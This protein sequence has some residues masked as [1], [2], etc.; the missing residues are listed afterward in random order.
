ME[1]E[2]VHLLRARPEAAPAASV[3]PVP[4]D[5]SRVREQAKKEK[6]L[7]VLA[8]SL[9][10]TIVPVEKLQKDIATSISTRMRTRQGQHL[11]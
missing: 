7:F 2:Q 5:R 1:G 4:L 8:A 11:W 3:S 9:G 10:F 6:E